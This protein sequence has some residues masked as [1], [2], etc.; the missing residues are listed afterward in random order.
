MSDGDDDAGGFLLKAYRVTVEGFPG[1]LY[2]TTTYGRALAEA[3]RSYCSYREVSYREFLRIARGWREDPMRPDFGLPIT[4]GGKPAFFVDSN[5]QYVQFT[6]PG[7]TDYFNAHPF[8]V[9]PEHMRPWTYRS[10][11]TPSIT[12][13][14][15]NG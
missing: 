12:P 1:Y 7:C 9:E 3:W 4:V 6:R 8:D 15:K 10:D 13:E 14:S 11:P 2:Y 5:N